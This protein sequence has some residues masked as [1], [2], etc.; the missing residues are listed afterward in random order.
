MV[1]QPLA[2]RVENV[3]PFN[4]IEFNGTIELK[5]FTDNWVRN[6]QI[7]GGVR[8]TGGFNGSYIETIKTSSVPDTHIRSRNVAFTPQFFK[9][10]C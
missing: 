4:M 10:S 2:S 8:R 3:N 5:P 6:V 7:D 1:R 9:T